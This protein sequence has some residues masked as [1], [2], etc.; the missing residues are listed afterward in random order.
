M[1]RVELQYARLVHQATA[2]LPAAQALVL[3]DRP[4]LLADTALL[5]RLGCIP[6]VPLGIMV[7]L[8]QGR[9]LLMLA[10]PVS[11][12][13]TAPLREVPWTIVW[14]VLPAL[15]V[16]WRARLESLAP[17]ATTAL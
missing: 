11:Q 8:R 9:L 10:R 17:Q 1:R 2:A 12:G 3:S 6:A 13:I 16:P 5:R 14:H 7:L 4:A 15:T